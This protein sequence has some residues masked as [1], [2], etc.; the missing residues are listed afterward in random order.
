[1]RQLQSDYRTIRQSVK[2]D[3]EGREPENK[4][5]QESLKLDEEYEERE[6]VREKEKKRKKERERER[7]REREKERKFIYT[8]DFYNFTEIALQGSRDFSYLQ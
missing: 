5:E 1:M 4:E 7:E 6:C 3:K 2:Q 8:R